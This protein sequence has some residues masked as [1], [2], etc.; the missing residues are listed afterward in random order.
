MALWVTSERGESTNK[1]GH[2]TD[3]RLERTALQCLSLLRPCYVPSQASMPLVA[4]SEVSPLVNRARVVLGKTQAELG[5][6]LGVARRTVIRWNAGSVPSND[7]VLTL[8]KAVYAK[9]P[10]LA[11]E[12]AHAAGARLEEIGLAPRKV[13]VHPLAKEVAIDSVVCAAAEAG[14]ATPQAARAGL[15]AGLERAAALGVTIEDLRGALRRV[16]S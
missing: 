7:Q 13:E 9:D 8:A 16:K 3:H 5:E 12:L 10:G 6:M 14:E 1:D 2:V 4:L 11:S 15:L